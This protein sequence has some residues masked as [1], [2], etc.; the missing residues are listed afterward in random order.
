MSDFE[1]NQDAEWPADWE[2]EKSKTQIKQELNA[3]KDLGRTLIDLS[4]KDLQKLDLSEDLYDAIIS[5]QSM[6]K[7]ALKRQVG[8]I[9]GMIAESDHEA[10]SQKLQQLKQ[11]HQG[12]VKQF[13]QLEQW[14]DRLL[15]GENEVYGELIAEFDAFD[16]QH[17]RQLVRNAQREA[18][19]EK[20]PKSARQLF[21]YLQSQQQN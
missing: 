7:G 16:V 5:A 15:A 2:F 10:I 18:K 13:H 3:L 4:A 11:P 6:S 8:Y 9:G 19:Q 17:V 14:R 1:D 21:Q 12:Q 20:P